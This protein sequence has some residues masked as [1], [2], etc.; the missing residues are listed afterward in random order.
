MKY[1]KKYST[2]SEY[3]INKN[4]ILSS[5]PYYSVLVNENK[6][7]MI[8]EKYIF[9]YNI[10][11]YMIKNIQPSYNDKLP[12]IT[13]CDLFKSITIDGVQIDLQDKV[14]EPYK[15][16]TS[17]SD[18][19]FELGSLILTD[20][21]FNEKYVLTK[22]FDKPQK[23]IIEVELNENVETLIGAFMF[24][25]CLFSID[26]KIF[27]NIQPNSLMSLFSSCSYLVDVNLTLLN[28][29]N[30]DNMFSMFANCNELKH[31]S[32]LNFNTS[33]VTDMNS[34]FM[35]CT[36]LID[37]DLSHFNTS[38]VTNMY[39]MFL[40]CRNLKTLNLSSFDTSNVID[41]ESMF[42]GCNNLTKLYIDNFS[43]EKITDMNNMFNGCNNL[44]FIQCT[45][46]FKNWCL[47]N[48]D[49]I[50]LP[51]SMQENGNGIWNIV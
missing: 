24:D 42:N 46:E 4:G 48:K 44:N 12:L 13:R 33:N 22:H 6:N 23:G 30:V 3:E 32:N 47:S 20:N 37:L 50:K 35:S 17:G 31:I 19:T 51:S 28:T 49:A 9:H 16:Q 25:L 5:L 27:E 41:F 14:R 11:D 2:I 1:I 21:G 15:F 40:N 10:T 29:D 34:M 36:N 7:V 39:S 8:K 38:K 26:E 18:L 45:E 43:I